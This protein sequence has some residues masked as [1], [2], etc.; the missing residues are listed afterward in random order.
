M[1]TFTSTLS[2][3]A[4]Y[5]HK[6]PTH[7]SPNKVRRWSL[8]L[9]TELRLFATEFCTEPLEVIDLR[10]YRFV[11]LLPNSKQPYTFRI[12]PIE[13]ADKAVKAK[14]LCASSKFDFLQWIT[15]I[16]SR[17]HFYQSLL[18]HSE[19]TVQCDMQD[20]EES[21][22][23][24]DI[25]QRSYSR[26]RMASASTISCNRSRHSSVA[27]NYSFSRSRTSS[28]ASSVS[29]DVIDYAKQDPLGLTLDPSSKHLIE[30]AAA[31]RAR[32]Q[33]SMT[34]SAPL[35]FRT[36]E[37][38]HY[39][40]VPRTQPLHYK[41]FTRRRNVDIAPLQLDH[42]AKL[43]RHKSRMP[44]LSLSQYLSLGRRRSGSDPGCTANEPV[45]I[46]VGHAAQ[47]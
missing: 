28:A 12:D 35:P 38:D 6:M 34:Y 11:V 31:V 4:G 20:P 5:L 8:L 42:P 22:D 18:K 30:S 37:A 24:E 23:D 45:V 13:N 39:R 21:A 1:E 3:K 17:I 19:A 46:P 10:Q 27:S 16:Q 36:E 32:R 7:I 33:R 15:A 2:P 40:V 29:P 9:A 26:P 47:C 44:A 14:V 43:I 41:S 25:Y